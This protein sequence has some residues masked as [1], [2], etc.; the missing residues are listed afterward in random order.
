MTAYDPKRPKI[1]VIYESLLPSINELA[2]T[3]NQREFLEFLKANLNISVIAC[4]DFTAS[5]IHTQNK[6]SLH[7]LSPNSL[8]LYQQAIYSVCD[9]LGKYDADNLI[10]IYG[11]GANIQEPG[12][13]YL[14][15]VETMNGKKYEPRVTPS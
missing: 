9:V 5:N 3:R 6:I 8:N 10:P 1:K 2:I 14:E 13:G 12:F 11:F 4:V 7:H 15:E